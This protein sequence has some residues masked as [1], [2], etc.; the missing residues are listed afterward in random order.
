M[1]IKAIIQGEGDVVYEMETEKDL[2]TFFAWMGFRNWSI[3]QACGKPF[4]GDRPNQKFCPKA[5]GSN[6]SKK[7]QG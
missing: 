1:T 7:R 5:T 3:C 2:L 4:W 6:C